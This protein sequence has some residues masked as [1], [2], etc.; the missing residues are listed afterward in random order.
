M[1]PPIASAFLLLA[2]PLYCQTGSVPGTDIMVYDVVGVTV[3][4]RQ[5]LA[6][7]GGEAGV[8]IGHSHCNAGTVHLPWVG[9]TTGGVMLDTY[10]KIAFL[11]ARESNGRLVQVS[12]KSY[13]KHSRVA[14][15]FSSGPCAPCQTGPPQTFRIGCSDTYSTG[16]NGSQSNLG[17]T[18]EI[19]P[20]LGSWN[21][22]GSYFDRGD[23]PVTGP[24]ATDGIQS[25]NVTGFG[26]V[27]NRMVVP[28]TELSTPGTFYG[29]VHLMIKG[30]PVGNRANNLVSRG[31]SFTWNG[32]SWT[33][34]V[35]GSSVAGS[36]LTRWAGA[37]TDLGGNGMD[38]GR[39]LVAVKV[40]G[41]S[42]GLWHYEFAVQ[43]LDNTRGGASLRIPVCPTARVLN[44]GF[45][46]IDRDPLNQW[47]A[48]R[49]AS[50]MAFLASANNSLDW[51]CIY[52]FW[53]DSDAAPVAGTV[54]LDEARIGPGALT[55]AVASQVPGLLGTEQLGDGCGTPAPAAFP[56][57]VPASPN[58]AYAIQFQ[59]A[60]AAFLVAAFAL[61]PAN[62]PLGS[63]CTVFLDGSQLAVSALVQAD[64]AGAAS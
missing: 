49:S 33:S 58:P 6:Y 43:N 5:G 59:T 3:A 27:K 42:N 53:F 47:T 46:D 41:P 14:F 34:A 60:P 37:S 61:A 25:L 13:L 24:A 52:N 62:L 56:N 44:T 10:P 38:D 57:G 36:V 7:P 48:S 28:E 35:A 20:W 50:E 4:G 9:S 32:T 1:R 63:G 8:I 40:T 31:L 30:E 45:R 39:F 18:D 26:P 17:P 11:L 21:P 22:V 2:T 29:Q 15:N 54:S 23:P 19:D 51:N 64:S 12:G 55:V 16:F